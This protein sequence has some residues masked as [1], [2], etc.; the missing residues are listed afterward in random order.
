MTQSISASII[1]PQAPE[2]GVAMQPITKLTIAWTSAADG[3]VNASV[4]DEWG[5]TVKVSGILMRVVTIPSAVT[6]PTDQYDIQILD[7]NSVDILNGAGADRSDASTEQ[8]CP[9]VSSAVEVTI[10]ATTITLV[11]ANAGDT[12]SGTVYLYLI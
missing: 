2:A 12:K 4:V 8:M 9:L 6:A 3:S 7:N 10:A 1:R 11:I 5:E